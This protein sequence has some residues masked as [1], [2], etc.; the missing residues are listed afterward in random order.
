VCV[1]AL[2]ATKVTTDR[3]LK[4]QKHFYNLI[5]VKLYKAKYSFEN[6]FLNSKS[7]KRQP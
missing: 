1:I 5:E 4:V 3:L 7:S 6:S 2:G